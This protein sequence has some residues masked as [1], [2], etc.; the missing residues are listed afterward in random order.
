MRNVFYII[1]K[2]LM[3]AIARFYSYNLNHNIKKIRN[4]FYTYW[5]K[6]FLG[7]LGDNSLISYP[8]YLQGGGQKKIKIGRK[9]HIQRH[10]ILACWTCHNNVNYTPSITIGD[11]CNIGD[12]TQI[13]S[14][15]RIVIGNGVLMGRYVLITDNSHGSLSR[16][17]SLI[18][19]SQRNLVSKGAVVIGNNTWI[20]ERVVILPGVHIGDNVVIGA[21]TVVTK[22]IPSDSMV[23]GMGF[24]EVRRL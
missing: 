16:E 1:V 18:P 5:L 17:E 2:A 11:N 3:W 4:V 12:Y 22:D 15:N 21:N 20:G 14:C 8:C 10:C 9:T 13:T 7:N 19:P 23:C 6:C 24:R